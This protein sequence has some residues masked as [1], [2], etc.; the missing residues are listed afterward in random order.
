MKS[1]FREHV[2]QQVRLRAVD[3]VAYGSSARVSLTPNEDVRAPVSVARELRRRGVSGSVA[4]HA[5]ER[6]LDGSP[7]SVFLER[8][9]ERDFIPAMTELGVGVHQQ[10]E[11]GPD[12]IKAIR[13]RL[14]LSQEQFA[15]AFTIE[16]RTLQNWEQGRGGLDAHTSLLFRVIDTAPEL[17]ERVAAAA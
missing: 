10:G 17:V 6:L 11:V 13:R 16:L 14:G 9:D 3:P 4:R 15:N 1:S 2:A 7:A 5:V 8:F 12:R